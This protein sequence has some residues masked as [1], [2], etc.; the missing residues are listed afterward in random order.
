MPTKQKLR[1][2]VTP[3]G[4]DDMGQVLSG[5][6]Y[7]FAEAPLDPDDLRSIL[8]RCDALFVNC[9]SCDLESIAEDVAFF[10]RNGGTVFASDWACVAL[11]S[12]DTRGLSFSMD[13]TEAQTLRAELLDPEFQGVM[14]TASVEITFDLGSWAYATAIPE[15]ARILLAGKVDTTGS[16]FKRKQTVP[17]AFMFGYGKGTAC[18][19]SF[20]N[21]AQT[22]AL[23]K[24]LLS[25]LALAPIAKASGQSIT[26]LAEEHGLITR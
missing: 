1:L 20:H 3:A 4:Y 16:Y 14:N 9:A 18:F 6:G 17:L 21:H 13:H 7:S 8:K 15:G 25:L 23:E 10:V 26:K 2:L 19:T 11:D 5:L 24:T 22:G 12:L